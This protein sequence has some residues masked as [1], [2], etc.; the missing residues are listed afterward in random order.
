MRWSKWLLGLWA[1]PAESPPRTTG[2]KK[3]GGPGE[4]R[5]AD[6]CTTDEEPEAQG[7]EAICPAGEVVDEHLSP[8]EPE[9]HLDGRSGRWP[10]LALKSGRTGQLGEAAGTRHSGSR[11]LLHQ[12]GP[13]PPVA[14]KANSR[15][16]QGGCA[17]ELSTR[18]PGAQ[19]GAQCLSP[20]HSRLQQ[21]D[22]LFTTSLRVLTLHLASS[23][24][25]GPYLP[26]VLTPRSIVFKLHVICYVNFFTKQ[27]LNNSGD[28]IGI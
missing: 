19:V 13:G 1:L 26:F 15:G 18:H 10:Q 5:G 16:T 3:P 2:D 24:L 22:C 17:P 20:P 14:E 23:Y 28:K 6:S 27:P 7:G 11:G 25:S 8:L 12:D 21:T 9:S 4:E